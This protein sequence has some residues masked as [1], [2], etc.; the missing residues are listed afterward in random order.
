MGF[1]CLLFS[2]DGR[3]IVTAG[4]DTMI[5][6]YE[7]ATGKEVRNWPVPLREAD[8]SESTRRLARWS[9]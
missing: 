9:L 3:S 7:T 4:E 2:P 8:A 6:V 1:R 5:R